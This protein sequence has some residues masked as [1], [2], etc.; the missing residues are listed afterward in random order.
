MINLPHQTVE[1]LQK[2]H[3]A[4]RG[5]QLGKQ[6]LTS[7]ARGKMYQ[8][9][10]KFSACEIS[11]RTD[12]CESQ[13]SLPQL[14]A[15]RNKT[16]TC[17]CHVRRRKCTSAVPLGYSAAKNWQ[18]TCT[19]TTTWPS[20]SV[21][22]GRKWPSNVS[23]LAYQKWLQISCFRRHHSPAFNCNSPLLW[24]TKPPPCWASWSAISGTS[25]P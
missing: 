7:Y 13:Q 12:G 24:N 20:D 25:S 17:T 5:P 18:M 14:T 4:L 21:F 16:N 6:R 10:H 23:I 8:D 22:G 1:K 11:N 3:G 15:R 19:T 9:I 2:K